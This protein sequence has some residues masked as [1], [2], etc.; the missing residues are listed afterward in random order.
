MGITSNSTWKQIHF[1]H[2]FSPFKKITFFSR[3]TAYLFFFEWNRIHFS[4]F[5]ISE[6]HQIERKTYHGKRMKSVSIIKE[7]AKIFPD[8]HFEIRNCGEITFG[9]VV[10]KVGHI[11]KKFV[12]ENANLVKRGR[13]WIFRKKIKPSFFFFEKKKK[14]KAFLSL[15]LIYFVIFISFLDPGPTRQPI[16]SRLRAD[17]SRRERIKAPRIRWG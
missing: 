15:R 4:S 8:T 13:I 2:F 3:I 12:R 16:S 5:P 17:W 9:H 10:S 1:N 11:S 7:K 14:W 6:C